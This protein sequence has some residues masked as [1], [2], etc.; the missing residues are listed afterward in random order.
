MNFAENKTERPYEV[1][2]PDSVIIK[3]ITAGVIESKPVIRLAS[4]RS[5]CGGQWEGNDNPGQ[6]IPLPA[7]ANLPFSFS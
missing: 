1:V 3:I 6:L 4:Q 2:Q 5:L 7:P